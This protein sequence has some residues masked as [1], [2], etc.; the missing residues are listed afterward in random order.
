MTSNRPPP[1]SPISTVPSARNKDKPVP[2]PLRLDS[3][4]VE[5]SLLIGKVLQKTVRSYRHPM[6]TFHFSDSSCY[7]VHVEGYHPNPTL[8]GVPK[9]LEVNTSFEE[10]LNLS[11]NLDGPLDLTVTNCSFIR[12]TDKAFQRKRPEDRE[13]RW[14]QNHL[15]LAFKF[16]GRPNWHC[17]W[18]AVVDH[19]KEYGGREVFRSY[20]DVYLQGVALPPS[21]NSP[22]RPH[23]KARRR[24][25]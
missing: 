19:D 22:A 21:P 23:H 25:T 14:D 8:Q 10:M 7:Q 24:R 15:G 16:N 4:G 18:A 17:V 3:S 12:L 11:Q 13:E 5:P 2:T 20:E 6:I 9:E 1:L